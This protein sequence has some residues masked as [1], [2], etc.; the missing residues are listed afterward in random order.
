MSRKRLY[1]ENETVNWM[2]EFLHRFWLAYEPIL[3]ATVVATADQTMSAAAPAGIDSLRMSTFT[4]GT[5]APRIGYIRTHAGT[6]TDEIVMDWKISFLPNDIS[7]LTV[8]EAADRINPKIVLAIKAGV[9]KLTLTKDIVVED[10]AFEGLMRI[11]LK[12]MNNFPHIK[13]ADFSF[14]QPPII[15]YAAKPIGF[16]LAMIPGLENFINNQIHAV[17]GPMMYDPNQFTIDL[18]QLLSSAPIDTAIG[19]LQITVQNARDLKAVKFGG[20]A[21]DPYISFGIGP[22]KDLARTRTKHCTANPRWNETTSLL[23]NSLKDLLLLEVYDYND[24][25]KDSDIGVATF[26]LQTLAEDSVQEDLQAPV[27]LDG[28]RRGMLRFALRFY[29]VLT[30]AKLADGTEEP[31]PD[32]STLCM[33]LTASLADIH[34][35]QRLVLSASPCTRRKISTRGEPAMSAILMLAYSCAVNRS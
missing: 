1:T 17:L 30:P 23:V 4:L 35:S 34:R 28:K 2:N 29:P 19:V 24:R 32:S 21:P 13:S 14:M 18:E 22:K 6:E 10:I 25:R 3:S 16:D 12:L 33:Y 20:G 11:R 31:L 27:M 15:D 7:N 8:R 9:G 26:D 5:K